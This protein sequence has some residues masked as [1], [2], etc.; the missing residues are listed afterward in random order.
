[1]TCA[2]QPYQ[3]S[4]S[5][6]IALARFV[7]QIEAQ[8]LEETSQWSALERTVVF[9]LG[10]KRDARLRGPDDRGHPD[11]GCVLALP[12][13]HRASRNRA[14]ITLSQKPSSVL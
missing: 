9:P 14:V 12:G 8:R 11:A 2:T 10:D 1:L 5:P 3:E 7:A 6:Q 13:R 4:L